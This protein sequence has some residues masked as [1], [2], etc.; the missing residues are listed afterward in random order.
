[1]GA[2]GIIVSI[3]VNAVSKGIVIASKH[4]EHPVIVKVGCFNEPK[5]RAVRTRGVCPY[6]RKRVVGVETINHDDTIVDR[7][8]PNHDLLAAVTLDIAQFQVAYAINS[9]T[10]IDD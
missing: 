9:E 6:A 10:I 3:H 1:L 5:W 2:G 8:R 7:V 4:L